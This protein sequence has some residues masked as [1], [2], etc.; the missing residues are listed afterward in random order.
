MAGSEK[1]PF[2]QSR[3]RHGAVRRL[4]IADCG[5]P[6]RDA[7]V[8]ERL[9]FLHVET[10]HQ[11]RRLDHQRLFVPE[12]QPKIAQSRRAGAGLRI[13]DVH[14][15]PSGRLRCTCSLALEGFASVVP[16]QSWP[17]AR[18]VAGEPTGPGLVR[19]SMLLRTPETP[20][21]KG[22]A[23]LIRPYG[24]RSRIHSRHSSHTCAGPR[25][26]EGDDCQSLSEHRWP[27]TASNSL[28]RTP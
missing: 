20:A 9:I 27:I 22:W 5:I 3:D 24:P 8:R 7:T 23:I 14:S 10:A 13:R 4:R 18:I 16:H 26:D 12:G 6:I 17:E 19:D 25:A 2:F 21:L 28:L 11:L 1:S 15:V